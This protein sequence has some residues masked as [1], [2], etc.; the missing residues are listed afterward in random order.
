MPNKINNSEMAAYNTLRVPS[1]AKAEIPI[2]VTNPK[3]TIFNIIILLFSLQVL[4]NQ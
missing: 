2:K 4:S 3:K 1:N